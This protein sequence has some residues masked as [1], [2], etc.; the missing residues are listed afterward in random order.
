M[1]AQGSLV[2]RK[3]RVFPYILV[4][5]LFLLASMHCATAPKSAPEPTPEKKTASD[6]AAEI[7]AVLRDMNESREAQAQQGGGKSD[8]AKSGESSLE[9]RINQQAQVLAK[10]VSKSMGIDFEKR[11]YEMFGAPAPVKDETVMLEAVDEKGNVSEVPVVVQTRELRSLTQ[12]SVAEKALRLVSEDELATE[13]YKEVPEPVQADAKNSFRR[14]Y[15]EVDAKAI[16][17]EARLIVAL[18]GGEWAEPEGNKPA[19]NAIAVRGLDFDRG[20][21]TNSNKTYDDTMY[22]VVESPSAPPEVFEYRMTTESSSQDKGVGRLKSKQVTYVRGKHRGTDP[23]Y[24]LLGNAAP[25][26]RVGVKG[27]QQITGANIH[28]AYAKRPINSETPL[29]PNVSLGCQVIAASK[30]DFEKGLV[31]MLDQREVK[32]FPYT[33]VED[34]E[35]AEFDKILQSQGEKS[36]LADSVLR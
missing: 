5:T 35:F 8:A 11:V 17:M 12:R 30:S 32:Q 1:R 19:A 14:V 33:I 3:A 27:E 34:A 6:Y 13:F 24:R 23:A 18:K 36:V 10:A 26:T 9:E 2:M 15:E 25:G 20:L 16:A 7:G 22:L 29:K 4:L 28:S 31:Q 21:S